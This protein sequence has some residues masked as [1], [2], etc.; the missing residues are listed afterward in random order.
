MFLA[1][2]SLIIWLPWQQWMTYF[3]KHLISEDDLYIDLK[4]HNVS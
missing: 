1:K 3:L 4:S 2:H